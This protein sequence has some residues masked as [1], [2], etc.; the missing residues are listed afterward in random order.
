MSIILVSAWPYAQ[1]REIAQGV[2]KR[3][4][5]CALGPELLERVARESK[6]SPGRLAIALGREA[7][8]LGISP[9]ERPRLLAHLE[10]A[11]LAGLGPDK[12]V[13]WGLGAHLYLNG[14]SHVLKARLLKPWD[15]RVAAKA[16]QEGLSRSAAEKGL[17]RQ[18]EA[19]ARLAEEAYRK[20]ET[21][22]DIF[23]LTI[24]LA[25]IGQDQAIRLIADTAGHKRFQPMTFSRQLL[26][27]KALAA[28][29]RAALVDSLPE[30]QVNAR[31]GLVKVRV[32]AVRRDQEKKLALARQ[33]A[34]AQQGVA[35]LEVE[36]IP[37]Y[38]QA[39]AESMR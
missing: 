18:D 25:Q 10:A 4:G 15:Q 29:V 6:A 33:L 20:R 28:A 16:Q 13:C 27:D 11:V 1:G 9:K 8:L 36:I 3:L 37:D 2:A 24:N 12:A 7:P 26:A 34:A 32:Q 23:D 39:A 38:F 14:V 35:A 5:Y 21:D 31:A 19:C 30:A 17:R 22:P